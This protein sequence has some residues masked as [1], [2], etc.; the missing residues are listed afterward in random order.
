VNRD[1]LVSCALHEAGH[2]FALLFYGVPVD[3]VRI[4][5]RGGS[6]RGAV[7]RLTPERQCVVAMAGA[8]AAALLSDDDDDDCSELSGAD[9][10]IIRKAQAG[11]PLLGGIDQEKVLRQAKTLIMCHE[12]EVVSIANELLARKHLSHDTMGLLVRRELR[13]FKDLY[14]LKVSRGEMERYWDAYERKHK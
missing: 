5:E 6:C 9:W 13:Q 11:N 4:G 10:N 8:C 14:P 1:S 2:A 7:E 3:S 12:R